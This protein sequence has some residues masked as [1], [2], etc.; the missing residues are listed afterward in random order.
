[1]ATRTKQKDVD[2]STVT[3]TDPRH[4][5]PDIAKAMDK[6][7][8]Q[9]DIVMAL[10]EDDDYRVEK[11]SNPA[12]ATGEAFESKEVMYESIRLAL[13]KH[14]LIENL[15]F[16][17]GDYSYTELGGARRMELFNNSIDEI[18]ED[19][20]DTV[21]SDERIVAW[22]LSRQGTLTLYHH[23]DGKTLPELYSAKSEEEWDPHY[24]VHYK[25]MI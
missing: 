13:R 1:M 24:N 15:I 9:A 7:T 16:I 4:S 14:K 12:L 23:A 21:S 25:N 6:S 5:I 8:T 3:I 22:K 20:A 19:I 10:Q 11:F 17:P 2:T 18:A